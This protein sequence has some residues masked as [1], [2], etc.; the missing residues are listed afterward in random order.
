MKNEIAKTD[1]LTSLKEFT[2]ARIAIGRVG[3]SI[4]LKQSLEFKLAHAHAR[5]AVYSVLDKEGLTNK[6][7]IFK[8]P[9][10]HLNSKA[11][12]RHKYLKR[13]DWGRQLD[14]ES[15]EQ[16]RN[17]TIET[18]VA[19]II[20]DGLSATAVNEN[21]MGLIEKLIPLLLAAK[22]SIAPFCL[23][24]QGRVAIGDEIAHGINAK[25]SVVLIG[26]RPGLSAADSM[27]AYLT[28]N[29]K[30]GLTDESR[31]CISNIRPHGL[32]HKPA[33][34]KIWYLINEAFKRKLSGVKLK[35]NAGLIG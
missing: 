21:A 11:A 30:P 22:L 5:D 10:L 31:N 34:D 2:A 14:E 35:D 25:L 13:P 7:N 6:L 8:L 33:A 28:Y 32:T 9:V 1:P 12:S 19:F 17:Y 23:V 16:I 3:T 29:P 15:A 18:D 26:E 20:I 24:E 27:G 4:P